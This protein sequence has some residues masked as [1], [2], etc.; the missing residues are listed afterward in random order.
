MKTRTIF[1]FVLALSGLR[2]AWVALNDVAPQEA[3]FW[4]CSTRLAPAFFDGPPGTAFLVAL[5]EHAGLPS[6]FLARMLWPALALVATAFAWLLAKEMFD[7][8]AAAWT[9]LALNVIPAFNVGATV[10]GAAMPALAFSLAGIWCVR[11]AWDG[12]RT[13]WVVAGALFAIAAAFRYEAVLAPIGLIIATLASSRHRTRADVAGVVWVFVA[14]TLSLWGPFNWNAALEWIPIAGGTVR[15]M[16]EFR[17]LAFPATLTSDN[18][19]VIGLV[20]LVVGGVLMLCDA[21]LHERSRFLF[22]ACGFSLAWWL[23]F[24]LRGE[25]SGGAALLAAGPILV[26]LASRVAKYPG[27]RVVAIV[28]CFAGAVVSVWALHLSVEGRSSWRS[29]AADLQSATRELPASESEGFFIAEDAG[30]ASI[31]GWL[32]KKN[33]RT[34]YPPV[35]VPESPGFPNQFGV[36]PSYADFVDSPVVVD[37]YFA[38][39]HQGVNP[40]VGRHAIFLGRDLPQTIDGAFEQTTPLRQITLPGGRKLTIY[41]CLNYQTLPL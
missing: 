40:F 19:S 37:E 25:G 5:C 8:R 36:W 16:W 11:R 7:E 13:F 17:W 24:S 6:L 3:Y 29:L 39:E 33:E 27:A 26:F 21:R 10:I 41:L 14:L 31:L 38:K 15:T 22:A 23:Y 32:L 9:A 34:A 28:V 4:L 20:I 12:R 18:V 30:S 35:F 2:W 1:L